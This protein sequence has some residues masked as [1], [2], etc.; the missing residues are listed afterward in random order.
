M[1]RSLPAILLAFF[2]LSC[3][4]KNK[5][6]K[7]VLSRPQMEAVLWDMISAD[8]FIAGFVLPKDTSLNK[9]QESTKLYNEIYQIHNTNKKQFEKSLLFYQS[10]PS[11]LMEVLDSINVKHPAGVSARNKVILADTLRPQIKK[12]E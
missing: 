1:I 2:I 9:K 3:S 11:L 10:H 5:I 7:D 8:E 12:I 6:P 4:G